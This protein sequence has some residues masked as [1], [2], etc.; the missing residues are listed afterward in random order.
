MRSSEKKGGGHDLATLGIIGVGIISKV[1][2]A[3]AADL[4]ECR[5][6]GICDV[7]PA[8]QTLADE[9]GVSVYSDYEEMIKSETTEGVIIAIPTKL[10]TPVGATCA[11][12]GIHLFVEK[13][14]AS[15]VQDA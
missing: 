6:L 1:H 9:L 14:I 12:H 4:P 3:I 7:N 15:D 2:A 5:L 8:A 10:H 11:H 13:P